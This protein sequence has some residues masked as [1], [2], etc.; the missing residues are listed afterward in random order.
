MRP[1]AD[2]YRESTKCTDIAQEESKQSRSSSDMTTASDRWRV[3]DEPGLPRL[4]FNTVVLP[5]GVTSLVGGDGSQ[6]QFVRYSGL[7]DA[8]RSA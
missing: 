7:I 4:A 6:R 3:R 2:L 5:G 1:I 8:S